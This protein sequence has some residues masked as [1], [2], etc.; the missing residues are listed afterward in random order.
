LHVLALLDRLRG[1]PVEHDLS[2]FRPTA[3]TVAALEPE[4]AALTDEGLLAR[5][6]RLRATALAT[7]ERPDLGEHGP[8]LAEAFA[9]VREAARRALGQRLFDEQVL[10]GLALAEGALAEMATGE[11]KT[12]AAVAPVFAHAVA[13][14][15]AHVLTFNDYLARRDAAWMGPVYER[16]GLTVGFVQERQGAAERRAA[17]AADVTYLTAKEA[18]F[19]HLRDGLSLEPGER[20]QRAYH[21]ALVDEADSILIDEARVPLVI[22]GESD[23]AVP[24]PSRLAALVRTLRAGV[25]FD[26]DE[27]AHNIALT[28]AGTARVEAALDCRG[29]LHETTHVALHAQLRHALHAEH[30][31]R[32]DVDYIVRGGRVELV[33]ESTGRVAERRH[34]PDGLQAAVEAKEGLRLSAEGRILGSVTLQHFLRLYPRLAGMTATAQPAADELFAFYGLRT[35]VVP[36]HRPMVRVDAP[37]LVFTHRDAKDEALVREITVVHATGR[38]VLVGTASVGESEALAAR[39]GAA[40]VPC[41]VLNAKND[42]AEAAVVAEAGAPGAVTISTNMAGRGTDIRLGGHDESRAA[43]EVRA[44]GGLLVIGTNRHASLRID[45]Q[46]RGRAGRQGDPGGSRFFVSLED[47]LVKRYG[48]EQLVSAR[49]LPARQDAPVESALLRA[50]LARAQRI[51]EDEG[52][53]TRRTLHAYSDVVERQ[54]LAIRRWRAAVLEGSDE[55]PSILAERCGERLAR[56]RPQVGDGVLAAVE[57]RLTLLAI[58]RCWSDHLAE[59]RELREDSVLLAFA[60]RYPVAEFHRQAGESFDAL[61]KRVVDEVAHDFARIELTRGGVDWDATGLRGPSATW[62]YLVGENPFGASGLLGP[63]GRIGMVAAAA[64]VPW[65]IL[66]QGAAVLW[67]RRRKK[68]A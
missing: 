66:L 11:G 57:R 65:L 10:A 26:T 24:E 68:K 58:D 14:R 12:L 7:E 43:A 37:D 3:T 55:G 15:G 5:A 47:P 34:W 9:L 61:E 28:E 8:A 13:G 33:D 48:V 18:G 54:R 60:G 17:Y 29:G 1:R 21:F 20:V 59:L 30:L 67:E 19:D 50:E 64:G 39:L 2:S 51:V 46:L 38:P 53:R 32:R 45:R 35:V 36:T 40:G 4:L 63:E 22:A 42:E 41:K 56:L 31:L 16:L 23:A 62:T 25:D 49:H 27:H 6:R 44:A 52:F